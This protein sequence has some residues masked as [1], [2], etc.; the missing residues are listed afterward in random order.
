[1]TDSNSSI[2]DV[3]TEILFCIYQW[4][5]ALTQ[6]IDKINPFYSQIKNQINLNM[7][8]DVKMNDLWRTFSE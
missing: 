7:L 4:E 8:D 3:E 1:M 2:K 6:H 5:N